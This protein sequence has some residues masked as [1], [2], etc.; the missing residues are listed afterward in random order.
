MADHEYEVLSAHIMQFVKSSQCSAYDC[1]F[2]ALVQYLDASL[3][4][5]DKKVLQEFPEITQTA[6]PYLI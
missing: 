3:I 5:A 6:E 4:T 2:I 1:D